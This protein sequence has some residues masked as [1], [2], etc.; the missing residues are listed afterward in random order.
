MASRASTPN[1]DG[2]LENVDG[3]QAPGAQQVGPHG[4]SGREVWLDT[5]GRVCGSNQEV[6]WVSLFIVCL[7]ARNEAR[8]GRLDSSLPVAETNIVAGGELTTSFMPGYKL[9]QIYGE[10]CF[11]FLCVVCSSC[12]KCV[13]TKRSPK[14]NSESTWFMSRMACGPWVLDLFSISCFKASNSRLLYRAAQLWWYFA[15]LAERVSQIF[16][17]PFTVVVEIIF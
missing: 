13:Y 8:Y 4:K 17:I 1:R 10:I 5:V 15:E 7:P 12:M 9:N 6:H 14:L 3:S 11:L 2:G 16:G